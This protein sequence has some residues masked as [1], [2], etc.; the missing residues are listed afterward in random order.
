M[1]KKLEIY[2][3]KKNYERCQG[4]QDLISAR[5]CHYKIKEIQELRSSFPQL[6]NSPT[7]KTLEQEA[8]EKYDYLCKT[9]ISWSMPDVYSSDVHSRTIS[10]E[11]H[12]AQKQEKAGC[13]IYTNMGIIHIIRTDIVGAQ[14][15]LENYAPENEKI[16]TDF[17]FQVIIKMDK[18]FESIN[19]TSGEIES[20]IFSADDQ[21]EYAKW[22]DVVSPR[23]HLDYAGAGG[24]AYILIDG[25]HNIEH[26]SHPRHQIQDALKI[27]QMI[28]KTEEL[29]VSVE[30]LAVFNYEQVD[31]L[32]ELKTK[33]L[34]SQEDARYVP[35]Y[36][37]TSLKYSPDREKILLKKGSLSCVVDST[38]KHELYQEL[39]YHDIHENGAF[40]DDDITFNEFV[41]Q[42]K[43]FNLSNEIFST[44]NTPHKS[45]IFVQNHSQVPEEYKAP[46]RMCTMSTF[47]TKEM[48]QL[49]K[50][51]VDNKNLNA[52]QITSFLNDNASSKNKMPVQA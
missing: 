16:L 23:I 22:E 21:I 32:Y 28:K 38:K 33:L 5:R 6:V 47:S 24:G 2:Q 41:D 35:L 49:A 25:V 43:K 30:L 20:L 8:V 11:Y 42:C 14:F 51:V 7:L 19:P 3:I 40:L 37:T 36:L 26:F 46:Y 50:E 48:W 44:K 12:E 18:E 45:S 13:D 29:G 4:V 1:S 31:E 15:S 52:S 9:S 10:Y 17:A 34:L 39:S 27:E